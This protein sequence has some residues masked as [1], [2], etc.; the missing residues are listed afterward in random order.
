MLKVLWS[1]GREIVDNGHLEMSFEKRVYEM[2]AD[3]AGAA[4][5]HCACH[6]TTI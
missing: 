3:E 5:H 4:C 2:A 6:N 1:P